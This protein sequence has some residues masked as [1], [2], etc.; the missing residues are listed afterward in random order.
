MYSLNILVQLLMS[1]S[2]I[3]KFTEICYISHLTFSIHILCFLT[4]QNPLPWR[5]APCK[6]RS[7]TRK[8][9]KKLF[10]CLCHALWQKKKH[11]QDA[12][13]MR[14]HTNK[15]FMRR[16]HYVPECIISILFPF[17]FSVY[18]A[19][20]KQAARDLITSLRGQHRW[21]FN[22]RASAS[23]FCLRL[24]RERRAC[25]FAHRAHNYSPRWAVRAS[26]FLIFRRGPRAPTRWWNFSFP[27]PNNDDSARPGLF[28]SFSLL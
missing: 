9:W 20:S 11:T 17:V 23:L 19:R 13:Y 5:F 4:I 7:K 8:I 10:C 12:M 16:V 3:S 26:L 1:T 18:S 2:L 24:E 25:P 21:N 14:F 15:L 6:F 22:T 27:R 28:R